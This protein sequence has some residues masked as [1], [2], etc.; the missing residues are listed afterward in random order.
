M[1]A[2]DQ[3]A[4]REPG[5]HA[6]RPEQP[7]GGADADSLSAASGADLVD[8][9]GAARVERHDADGVVVDQVVVLQP[10]RDEVSSLLVVEDRDDKSLVRHTPDPLV[11]G[12]E[13]GPSRGRYPSA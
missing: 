8:L 12:P 6:D 11:A 4:A 5:S 2:A 13:A 9:E 1:K 3:R 10:C 7:Q